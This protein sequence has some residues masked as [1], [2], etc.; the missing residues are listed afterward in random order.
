MKALWT[1]PWANITISGVLHAELTKLNLFGAK[2][3]EEITA[4]A[5]SQEWKDKLL[6]NT[7]KALDLGAFG[8]PWFWVRNSEGKEEPFFGSDR[9]AF[10]VYQ[11]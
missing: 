3:V 1:P 10:C 11:R 2:E 4:A 7:Q 6:A 9:Y 8:A 5:E